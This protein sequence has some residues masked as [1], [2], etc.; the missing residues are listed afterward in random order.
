MPIHDLERELE[1]MSV[2]PV[3][4]L[5]QYLVKDH[6]TF[7]KMELPRMQD[8]ARKASHGPLTQFVETLNAELRGHFKTE[9]NIVF[10]VL[11]S[12]EHKD[13]GSLQ[14]ALQYACRHM[15][16][17]HQRRRCCSSAVFRHNLLQ[18]SQEMY[19]D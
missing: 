17:D 7:L 5:V 15:E 12:M 19:K 4:R 10:P 13:P 9:E 16:S 8:S 6:E 1:E 18:H 2:W 3:E 14:Q 11:V